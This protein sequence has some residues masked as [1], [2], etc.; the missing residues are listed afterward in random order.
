MDKLKA[1]LTALK[2]HH[3][4]VLTAIILLVGLSTW[5]KAS[6]D[7]QAR[8]TENQGKIKT[9]YTML[10]SLGPG[11]PN[12]KFAEGLKTE[13]GT[14]KN[15]VF[16][17]WK[18]VVKKQR[19]ITQWPEQVAEIDK[20]G[21]HERIPENLRQTY[22]NTALPAEWKKLFDAVQIRHPK[23]NE[24]VNL[25]DPTARRQTVEYEGIVVWDQD[26]RDELVKRYQVQEI[27]SDLRVRVTQED[28]WVFKSMIDLIVQL[29]KGAGDPLAAVVKRIDKLELAQWA[30][31][32]AQKNPG[33]DLKRKKAGEETEMAPIATMAGEESIVPLPGSQDHTED[34][35]LLEGRY[36]NQNNQPISAEESLKNPPFAEFKQM[37]V[38]MQFV[39]DQRKIPD[40]L[41]ACANSPLRIEP[42]QVVMHF[43]DID[44]QVK[45]EA[46]EGLEVVQK[47]ERGPYDCVLQIRGIVYMYNEPDEPKLGTGSA[48]QPAQRGLGIPER[49]PEAAKM[50]VQEEQP[51]Y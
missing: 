14:L 20:L 40:L 25:D 30:I 48:P 41:A 34:K 42:R 27:P 21:A 10:S 31:S 28:M 19:D 4:W 16:D 46:G 37:F 32:D 49:K 12:E 2:K 3:F 24:P 51:A 23:G 26:K 38:D 13:R 47:L 6:W 1:Y 22:M 33:A 9:T 50:P 7:M 36:L 8:F 18:D 39:M 45:A 35:W 11:A 44:H 43:S 17:A 29:N 15:Q 5:A